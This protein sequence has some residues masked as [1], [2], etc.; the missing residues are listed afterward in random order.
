M[1]QIAITDLLC[2]LERYNGMALRRSADEA[3][4]A[5][6]PLNSDDPKIREAAQALARRCMRIPGSLIF[7]MHRRSRARWC[8]APSWPAGHRS[9][10]RR[11]VRQLGQSHSCSCLSPSRLI[12]SIVLGLLFLWARK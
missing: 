10:A 4:I 11:R 1:L 8:W 9:P 5:P 6:D 7:L 12:A 2:V 3:P